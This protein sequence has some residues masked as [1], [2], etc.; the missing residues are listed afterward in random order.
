MDRR[1]ARAFE[2]ADA[3]FVQ[4]GQLGDVDVKIG[5]QG[6]RGLLCAQCSAAVDAGDRFFAQRSHDVDRLVV[7]VCCQR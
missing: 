7:A 1:G 4:V 2:F 5:C 3:D 6:S